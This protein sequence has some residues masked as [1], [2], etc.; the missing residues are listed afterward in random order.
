[1]VRFGYAENGAPESFF[2][3]SR[4]EACVAVDTMPQRS[5]LV[6][7]A[8]GIVNLKG[9]DPFDTKTWKTGTRIQL[10][11]TEWPA[12]GVPTTS[13][14]GI[15][16]QPGPGK[17]SGSGNTVSFTNP[18]ECMKHTYGSR[19][20]ANGRAVTVT[21]PWQCEGG[22]S[23][24]VGIA[25]S[26]DWAPSDWTWDLG[27]I[28]DPRPYSSTFHYASEAFLGQPCATGCTIQ[29]PAISQRVLY[30]QVEY[31]SGRTEPIQAIVVP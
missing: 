17:V 12:Q 5:G 11:G 1:M 9:G 14:F 4:R 27:T 6:T 7:I 24:S 26:I 3:T 16:V 23:N 15:G 25:E 30:Y 22:K 18:G 2:C 8:N 19:I 29:I 28:T 13:T 10:L 21:N 20:I 31:D